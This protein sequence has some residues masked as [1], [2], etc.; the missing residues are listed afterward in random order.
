[1]RRARVIGS[2][3]A[4]FAVVMAG[5]IP[6]VADS[7][8]TY[9]VTI[10]NHTGG[11]PFTPPLVAS[12]RPS[13]DLFEVGQP[14]S[15]A[16]KEIAENGNLGPAITFA[17]ESSAAKH[18]SDAVVADG[19]PPPVLPGTT[20]EFSLT[21][22]NGANRVSWASMLICTNDGFTGVD[23]V[24]LPKRVGDSISL[25]TMAYDAGTE[26]NTENLADIVPPCQGLTGVF[27]D[28]GAPGT[29]MSDPLHAEGGVI[30]HHGGIVGGTDLVPAIHGW[31]GPVATITI[32]RD[33]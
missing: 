7:E 5:G 16:I 6:G 29:G 2:L 27:D 20:R 4:A 3:I 11:Q 26:I 19:P 24:R 9:T 14:A 13:V 33:S 17:T 30:H 12:H 25:D 32:T 15:E 18:V 10:T 21:S 22:S 28:E 23:S 31:T 8:A 1:M